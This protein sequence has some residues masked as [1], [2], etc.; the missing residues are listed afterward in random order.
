MRT[1]KYIERFKPD[2]VA[3]SSSV[4]SFNGAA[5]GRDVYRS[6]DGRVC[7]IKEDTLDEFSLIQSFISFCILSRTVT[8]DDSH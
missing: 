4:E 3:V 5:I 2:T 7:N 6:T 8:Q 1:V